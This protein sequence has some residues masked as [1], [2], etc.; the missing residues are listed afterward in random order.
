MPGMV[1]IVQLPVTTS[2]E[3][4]SLTTR[5]AQVLDEAPLRRTDG[6]R[7]KLSGVQPAAVSVESGLEP[8][9]LVADFE[10]DQRDPMIRETVLKCQKFRA[11]HHV[12]VHQLLGEASGRSFM[13]F[14]LLERTVRELP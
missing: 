1:L 11:D 4:V 3:Q 10:G 14:A 7:G 2:S 6:V 8:T 9:G 5:S 12:E 13:G